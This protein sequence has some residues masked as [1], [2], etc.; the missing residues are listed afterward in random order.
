MM[1]RSIHFTSRSA[2][3]THL[4]PILFLVV[5]SLMTA[6]SARA[7]FIID[8]FD[9][10]QVVTVTSGGSNPK[11]AFGS[12][13]A[14]EAVGGERDILVTR[15]GGA[16]KVEANVNDDNPGELSIAHAAA[17]DGK[18]LIIWDGAPDTDTDGTVDP[19]GLSPKVDVTQ[20]GVNQFLQV[21][22]ATDFQAFLTFTFYTDA[23]NYSTYK[24]TVPAD[25]GL[26]KDFFIPFSSFTAVGG[27]ANFASVGAITM[28]V[29]DGDA[30]D[31]RVDF[32]K[33]VANVPE[34][35]S[36]AL[37]LVGAG[38]W[39]AAAVARRRRRRSA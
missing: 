6:N 5:A 2:V 13:A 25:S 19:E 21:R 4:F 29:D 31:V 3:L 16:G 18:A 33:A 10:T 17:T 12:A 1:N 36:V 38:L 11:T 32:I 35:S 37:V 9:T 8:S 22:A 34:P 39:G 7:E 23:T 26:L 30:L 27:G 24:L 14:A 28:G 15:T 20:G